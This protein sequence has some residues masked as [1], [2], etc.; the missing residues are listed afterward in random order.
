[1]CTAQTNQ[2]MKVILSKKTTKEVSSYSEGYGTFYDAG[3]KK[4]GIV[5]S[6][7]TITFESPYKG[8]C[9]AQTNQYMKVILSKKTTKE[10]SSYSEGYGTF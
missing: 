6:L 1:V 7:G 3:Y 9:T 2:Y 4:P 10:V 8:V 5:D